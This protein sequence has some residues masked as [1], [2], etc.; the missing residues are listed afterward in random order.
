[1]EQKLFKAAEKQINSEFNNAYLYLSMSL[2][3]ESEDWRGF[4]NWMNVQ[5]REEMNHATTL[6]KQLQERGEAP[7]LSSIDTPKSMWLNLLDMME[8][9]LK[10][11]LQTTHNI[12]C[13][14]DIAH[15]EKDH[16]FYE[17]IMMYVKEQ[18]EEEDNARKAISQLNR[19]IN[20]TGL[21]YQM[22]TQMATRV[23]MPPFPNSSV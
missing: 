22:D 4:A 8:D 21:L 6:I 17:F 7:I 9:A 10:A 23:F 20:D 13:L 3:C 18:V 15:E 1:M 12:N 14:A 11:E 5:A 19:I 2:W 16:A